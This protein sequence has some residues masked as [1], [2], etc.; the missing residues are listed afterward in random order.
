VLAIIHL[1]RATVCDSISLAAL[2]RL[3]RQHELVLICEHRAVADGLIPTLRR[4]LPRYRLIAMAI[5]GEALHQER[6]LVAQLLDEGSIPLILTTSA[7]ATGQPTTWQ[8]IGAETT[9]ALPT[10]APAAA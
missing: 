7:T 3:A 1:S 4:A 9:M 5:D 2:A 6:E 10:E 8:W